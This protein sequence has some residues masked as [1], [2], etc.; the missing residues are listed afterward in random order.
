M[1]PQIPTENSIPPCPC[2]ACGA[3]HEAISGPEG[4]RPSPGDFS[5]CFTC[6]EVLVFQADLT[7]RCAELND[8]VGMSDELRKK[9][10][11]VQAAIGRR[12]VEKGGDM[13][14]W[15]LPETNFPP[16]NLDEVI[17]WAEHYATQFMRNRGRVRP[18][19]LFITGSGEP[20]IFVYGPNGEFGVPEKEKFANLARIMAVALGATTC[21]FVTETW[22]IRRDGMTADDVPSEAPDREEGVTIIGE[23]RE[24]KQ[25][26]GK[27]LRTI[28]TDN[29][30]F[31]NLVPSDAPFFN[32]EAGDKLTGR[33]GQTLTEKVPPANIQQLAQ[34]AL[35]MFGINPYQAILKKRQ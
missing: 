32:S 12:K 13:V 16:R 2:P 29:G 34:M 5:L 15:E 17:Q 6:G 1:N 20:A 19:F 3:M 26:R 4:K 22:S 18:A 25:I 23:A 27:I 14:N 35:S 9:V 33:F 30:K 24:G 28:R 8:L 11:T 7:T 31:F 21:A 10:E